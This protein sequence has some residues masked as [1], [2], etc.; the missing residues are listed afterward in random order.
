MLTD[1]IPALAEQNNFVGYL[2][3]LAGL[4]RAVHALGGDASPADNRREVDDFVHLLLGIARVGDAISRLAESDSDE[5]LGITD[6]PTYS[7]A[8]TRWLR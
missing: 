8:D 6:A 5:P 2:M 4:A 7:A 3:G 1:P